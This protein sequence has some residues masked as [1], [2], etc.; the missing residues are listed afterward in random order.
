MDGLGLKLGFVIIM[1]KFIDLMNDIL[2]L[3]QRLLMQNDRLSDLHYFK[4]LALL[5][6]IWSLMNLVDL[7]NK[8]LCF[9]HLTDLTIHKRKDLN[10]LSLRIKICDEIQ[11]INILLRTSKLFDYKIS[12]AIHSLMLE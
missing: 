7:S 1:E 3:Y 12:L 10:I 6:K 2:D 11:R 8:D 9:L 4:R 5:L